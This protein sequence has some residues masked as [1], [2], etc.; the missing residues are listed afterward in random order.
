MPF[1]CTIPRNSS[2]RESGPLTTGGGFGGN[3]HGIMPAGKNGLLDSSLELAAASDM[4]N[5]K[6]ANTI[7]DTLLAV[8]ACFWSR[9]LICEKYCGLRRMV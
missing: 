9:W 3:L 5:V 2:S 7:N 4:P 8:A 1:I 6:H